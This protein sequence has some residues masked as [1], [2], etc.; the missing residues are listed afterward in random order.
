MHCGVSTF[1]LF[2]CLISLHFITCRVIVFIPPKKSQWSICADK[3]SSITKWHIAYRCVT[4][5]VGCGCQQLCSEMADSGSKMSSLFPGT[6]CVCLDFIHEITPHWS[7]IGDRRSAGWHPSIPNCL[8]NFPPP[9]TYVEP[10][11]HIPGL[12]PL[13]LGP[14]RA[15]MK[16]HRPGEFEPS[17]MELQQWTFTAHAAL[18]LLTRPALGIFCLKTHYKHINKHLISIKDE[19]TSAHNK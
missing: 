15:S 8:W 3:F 17:L 18:G 5:G 16:S 14:L 4:V 1:K 2:K 10:S 7:T 9:S 6:S 11:L 19:L 13:S 12:T